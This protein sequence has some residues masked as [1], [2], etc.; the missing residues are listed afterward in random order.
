MK[1]TRS[2]G[3][4]I[5]TDRPDFEVAQICL[6]GHLITPTAAN[7]PG[8]R[9]KFC[10]RCGAETTMACPSCGAFIRGASTVALAFEGWRATCH[11]PLYCPECGEPYPWT[12]KRLAAAREAVE[13]LD[14]DE[15]EKE[16]LAED[17]ERITIN[18]PSTAPAAMRVQEV[19]KT[20]GQEAGAVMRE[21]VTSLACEA[22]KRFLL[23]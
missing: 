7:H 12:T 20:L 16:R 19:F 2:R 9:M 23:P 22:A 10:D 13:L 21:V 14:M 4:L 3:G 15:I 18:T 11:V 1:R 5:V 6:N 8:H 17:L